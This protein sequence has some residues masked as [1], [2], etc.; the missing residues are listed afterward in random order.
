[1]KKLFDILVLKSH[2]LLKKIY[3]SFDNCELLDVP[4]KGRTALTIYSNI[5]NNLQHRDLIF[6]NG[7]L[8]RVRGIDFINYKKDVGILYYDL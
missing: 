2:E 5:V 6:I 7:E 1:M 3:P 4:G 8:K